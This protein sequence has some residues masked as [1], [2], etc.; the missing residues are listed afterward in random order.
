[1][2]KF[3]TIISTH[4]VDERDSFYY[5]TQLKDKK[6]SI[7]WGEFEATGLNYDEIKLNLSEIPEWLH[8]SEYFQIYQ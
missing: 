6:L 8:S 1:M 3:Y 5:N 2:S 7:G 4:L